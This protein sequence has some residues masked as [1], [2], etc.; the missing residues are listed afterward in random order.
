ML[1]L[2]TDL[3]VVEAGA[4]VPGSRLRL[5]LTHVGL[6][7]VAHALKSATLDLSPQHKI[8]L[9]VKSSGEP[10]SLPLDLT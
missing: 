10:S 5:D 8:T 6:H 7:P 1:P 2:P 4:T 9:Q 3:A